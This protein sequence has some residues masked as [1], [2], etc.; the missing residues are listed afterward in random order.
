MKKEKKENCRGARGAKEDSCN[1]W[2]AL[3]DYKKKKKPKNKKRLGGRQMLR[4]IAVLLHLRP[5]SRAPAPHGADNLYTLHA[6]WQV[7][8]SHGT[9]PFGF[10]NTEKT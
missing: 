8:N 6:N 1:T 9:F 3:G 7:G 10:S 2:Q 5:G 4:S